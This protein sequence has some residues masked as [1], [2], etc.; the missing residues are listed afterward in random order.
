MVHLVKARIDDAISW[1]EK[2]RNAN[3]R[4]AGPRAW[5]ASA[6]ALAADGEGAAAELVEARR[7][8]GDNR[9]SSIAGF[10]RAATLGA[11]LHAIAEDT[12]FA[13]LR[14]AGVPEE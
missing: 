1:L 10:K 14:R 6:Y 5:L 13:G 7:L 4:L 3:P 11:K 12:L 9:Y 8:S 2:A